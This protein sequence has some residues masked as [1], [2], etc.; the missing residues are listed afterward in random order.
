MTGFCL[1]KDRPDRHKDRER[2]AARP[3]TKQNS[4]DLESNTEL[5]TGFKFI[6]Y[7]PIGG[8]K[9]LLNG[10]FLLHIILVFIGSSV[11]DLFL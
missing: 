8:H 3:S 6:H 10:L 5:S 4:T 1:I 2:G 7:L 9:L 11:S